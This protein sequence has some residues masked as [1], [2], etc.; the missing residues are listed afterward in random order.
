[1]SKSRQMIKR[2]G[3]GFTL[4]E[5]LIAMVV[6]SLL[7]VLVSS[8]IS[9]STR[10][11]QKEHDNL[12]NKISEFIYTEKLS[13]SIASMQPYGVYVGRNRTVRLFFQGDNSQITFVSENGL[14]KQGPVIVSVRVADLE[15]GSQ[16]MQI[17][18]VSLHEYMLIQE[19]DLE[20][21]EW[22][23][24]DLKTNLT[25]ARFVFYGYQRLS[26]LRLDR[27][28]ANKNKVKMQWSNSYQGKDTGI[29]P[30]KI[31]LEW[32]QIEQG[33]PLSFSLEFTT[34]I[35]D[36]DRFLALERDGLVN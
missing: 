25:N 31:A 30:H 17:A 4:V 28:V 6:F 3:A 8:S 5:V 11:W 35:D 16:S 21:L 2:E 7:M 20:E 19:S 27:T 23:W 36:A 14:Y 32:Q 29:L 9:F 13:R 34:M 24:Q 10:F 15:D 12:S 33:V 22:H 18:E 26:D 1:M